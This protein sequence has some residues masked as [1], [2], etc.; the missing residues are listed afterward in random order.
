M[1]PSGTVL[2]VDDDPD[3][4]RLLRLVLEQDGILVSDAKD[5]KAAYRLIQENDFDAVISDNDMPQMS[6]VELYRILSDIRPGLARRFIL[7][8]AAKPSNFDED[9]PVLLKPLDLPVF[10]AVVREI[11][12]DGD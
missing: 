4:R 10:I 3:I 5:G 12:D 11:L 8:T 2:V 9:C 1:P 7:F 6:G